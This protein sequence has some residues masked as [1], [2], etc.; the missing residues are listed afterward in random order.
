M[1]QIQKVAGGKSIVR[2]SEEEIQ[3]FLNEQEQSGLTV[4]EYCEM[5]DIVEQTFYGWVNRYRSKGVM[6]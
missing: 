1:E 3:R 5:Y 6:D 4:K 2:R